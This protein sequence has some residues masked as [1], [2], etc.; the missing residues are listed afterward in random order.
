MESEVVLVS[1]SYSDVFSISLD[2]GHEETIQV[3]DLV[4]TGPNLYP[5]FTVVAVSGDKA[6]VCNIQT[7]VDGLTALNRCRKINGQPLATVK[8]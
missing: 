2:R 8:E 7:G 1:S 6:W 5:R 4:Q 3:G